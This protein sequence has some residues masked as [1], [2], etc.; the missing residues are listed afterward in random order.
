[1]LR[2]GGYILKEVSLLLANTTLNVHHGEVVVA[3][4]NPA[5]R[6]RAAALAG[7]P[8]LISVLFLPE[9]I[10]LIMWSELWRRCREEFAGSHAEEGFRLVTLKVKLAWDVVG[11][12]ARITAALAAAGVSVGVL[13][14]YSGD[15]LL[16][17]DSDLDK[18][19]S[20]LRS[21]GCRG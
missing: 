14:G 9:E 12:L 20:A 10:T 15:H 17:K 18:V 21:L 13:T 8:D 1:M 19:L 6:K 2:Q 16:V 4:V 5:Y 3:G 7:K 11:Y